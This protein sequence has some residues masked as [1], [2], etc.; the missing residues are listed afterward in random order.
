[1]APLGEHQVRVGI[2]PIRTATVDRQ[3]IGQLLLP[4]QPLGEAR[5]NFPPLL[6]AQLLGQGELDLAV[7]PPVGPLVLV[8]RLPVLSGLGLR[9][10]RH[11]SVL[12]VFQ[13]IPVLLVAALALDVI[14][15]GAGRLPSGAGTET[16]F[17]MVYRHAFMPPASAPTHAVSIK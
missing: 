4:G 6:L 15:L 7:Q 5:G 11:V 17:Q 16:R 9:P 3:R 8:R 14:A 1:M 2:L 12:F 13:F 10:L